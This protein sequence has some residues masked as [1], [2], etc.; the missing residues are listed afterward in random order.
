M[1]IQQALQFIQEIRSDDKLREEVASS[2]MA[3]VLQELVSLGAERGFDFSEEELRRAHQ[4][5]WTMRWI[6]HNR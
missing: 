4:H 1:S 6:R 2:R 5:E 3:G